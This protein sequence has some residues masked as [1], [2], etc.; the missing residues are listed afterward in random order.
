MSAHHGGNGDDHTNP[1]PGAGAH[2]D[3]PPI[4]DRAIVEAF[5]RHLMTGFLELLA[6]DPD[7]P[8]KL[9][10]G[11]VAIVATDQAVAA[12]TT[13][14]DPSEAAGEGGIPAT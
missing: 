13:D 10:A 12:I 9:M 2:P 5:G 4:T 11:T 7:L 1:S 8:S 3:S 14:L 6:Q